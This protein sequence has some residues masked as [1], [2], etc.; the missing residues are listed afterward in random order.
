MYRDVGPHISPSLWKRRSK[1]LKEGNLEKCFAVLSPWGYATWCCNYAQ[2]KVV[3]S[4]R[5]FC[6]S[7]ASHIQEIVF[8][9]LGFRVVCGVEGQECVRDAV[10]LKCCLL[11]VFTAGPLW[12]VGLCKRFLY[13]KFLY[14]KLIF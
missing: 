3:F 7:F 11:R 13:F 9:S 4:S 10:N 6:L 12:N 5:D 14:F 2:E 8:I 1:L